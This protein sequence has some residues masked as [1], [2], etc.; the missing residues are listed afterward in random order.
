MYTTVP[1]SPL[2]SAFTLDVKSLPFK[3]S[4]PVGPCAPIPAS[5][6]VAVPD[7]PSR[8]SDAVLPNFANWSFTSLCNPIVIVSPFAVVTISLAAVSP[9][10]FN[11]PVDNAKPT[12]ATSAFVLSFVTLPAKF[13]VALPATVLLIRVIAS[14]TYFLFVTSA[15]FAAS[16][17]VVNLA[18]PK[19]TVLGT[20]GL[21]PAFDLLGVTVIVV[22]PFVIVN[23]SVPL[24]EIPFI[25]VNV[26]A[27]CTVNPL[28][29][30]DL[31]WIFVP[32]GVIPVPVVTGVKLVPPFTA[33][34][35]PNVRVAA[36]PVSALKVNGF[37]FNVLIRVS[38]LLIAVPTLSAVSVPA[39]APSVVMVYVGFVTV[40]S[41]PT[42]A[43]PPSASAI[44][45][46]AVC[47]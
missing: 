46:A 26:S 28:V 43:L 41:A 33:N 5:E 3:P 12:L 10:T 2:R 17:V 47:N 44:L 21:V 8:P 40:P 23:G 42:V 34:V 39:V 22:S 32:A 25:L 6:P 15:S 35:L 37:P 31:T 1:A 20:A 30:S 13:N 24:P 9:C 38:N 11:T 36:V 27:K 45:V 7:L 29:A 18:P 16:K 14:S 19:S 4:L